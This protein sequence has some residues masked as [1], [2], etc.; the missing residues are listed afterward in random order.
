MAIAEAQHIQVGQTFEVTI[1]FTGDTPPIRLTLRNSTEE[2]QRVLAEL[3]VTFEKRPDF[4]SFHA[5][6]L[7]TYRTAIAV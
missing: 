7:T 5:H 2:T 6:A 4:K 1:R 3:K